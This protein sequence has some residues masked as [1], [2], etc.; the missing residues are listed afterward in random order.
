MALP[1]QTFANL[2]QLINY[3]NTYF[4]PNGRKEIDGTEGNNILNSL[5][6]FIPIYTNNAVIGADIISTGGVVSLARP[7]NVI[8]QVAPTSV[9]WPNNIQREY[10]I[11]NTLPVE[12]PLSGVVYYDLG[13]AAKTTIPQNTTIHIAQ[14]ENGSWVQVNNLGGAASD[15]PNQGED[16]P[17]IETLT[18]GTLGRIISS[19]LI[20][21]EDAD[22]ALEVRD[23]GVYVAA[24]SGGSG[25]NGQ[26][27]LF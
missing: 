25:G 13:M 22:N 11:A 14:A 2:Q 26:G 7:V 10:Y 5:A 16:T 18:D 6:N 19:R 21:S 12:I 20:V 24:S 4:I 8:T 9:T 1:A 3:T 27:N 23:D 15:V 17:S